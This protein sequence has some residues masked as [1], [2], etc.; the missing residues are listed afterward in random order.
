MEDLDIFK[1]EETTQGEY[2]YKQINGVC[3]YIIADKNDIYCRLED[4]ELEYDK[5]IIKD[6]I[7]IDKA[8]YWFRIYYMN[9]IINNKNNEK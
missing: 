1:K 9:K 7:D 3:L 6:N 8:I 4:L 5:K 2:I